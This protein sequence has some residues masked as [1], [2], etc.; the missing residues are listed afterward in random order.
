LNQGHGAL[1]GWAGKT[2]RRADL[3]AERSDGYKVRHF[4][5]VDGVCA[6][7]ENRR[8]SRAGVD[9]RLSAMK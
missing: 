6:L 4:V 3:D 9:Q 5:L 2:A 1:D 8:R 7:K